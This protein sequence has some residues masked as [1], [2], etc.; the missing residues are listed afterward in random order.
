MHSDVTASICSVLKKVSN[1]VMRSSVKLQNM[2][3]VYGRK[4]VSA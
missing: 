2:F 3:E 4:R 1:M